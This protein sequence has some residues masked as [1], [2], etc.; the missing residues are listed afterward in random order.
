MLISCNK[1]K[2][3]IKN[4][5][6]I[7]WLNI[8]DTFTLR[9]AEVENVEV[10][11][12]KFDNVVLLMPSEDKEV[13][14]RK[15]S[16]LKGIEPNSDKYQTNKHFV[17]M[18]CNYELATITEYTNGKTPDEISTEIISHLQTKDLENISHCR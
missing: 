16:E 7:D 6:D 4:P 13:S 15:L 2:S 11:G 12:N 5:E 10:K 3:H 17:E 14:L 18:P 1:L 8:W 9:T